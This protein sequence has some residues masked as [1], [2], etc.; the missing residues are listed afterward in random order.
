VAFPF[1]KCLFFGPTKITLA[2]NSA[3]EHGKQG[4]IIPPYHNYNEEMDRSA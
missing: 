2:H 3:G 4:E 1:T